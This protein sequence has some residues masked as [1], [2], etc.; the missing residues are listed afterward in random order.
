MNPFKPTLAALIMLSGVLGGF[1][2]HAQ[3]SSQENGF[4][5]PWQNGANNDAT[6]RGLNFTIPDA[7]NLADFHGNPA[8]PSLSLYVGGNYY[9]AMAPL[10]A[11]FEKRYP[12]YKGHIYW[13]T[14]PPGR[15]IEQIKAGGTVTVGNMTW[16]V[17]PDLYFAGLKAVS[18]QIKDGLLVGPAVPYVTNNLTI[19]IPAGNPA[20]IKGLA[21]LGRPDVILAMPD[22]A[23]EGIARQIK[24]A[25]TNAG[26]KALAKMVYETKVAQGTTIL[27]RIHHRQTPLWLM[28]GKVQAGVTWQSEALFQEKAGHPIASIAIPDN[29]NATAIYAGA[30]VKDAPHPEAAQ[31]W[32][33][34]IRSPEGLAIFAEY[35]FKPYKGK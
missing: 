24:T 19:M 8:N 34:F 22:P 29:Q 18:K 20:G 5:P 7:D 2:A 35:G 25:L 9:F 23:F 15:L 31:R 11:A 28:Q 21:D 4:F 16:T 26:G 1:S 27:T 30:L 10:I 12:D 6:D 17:K 13:E 14:I 3:V 33:D 32:L